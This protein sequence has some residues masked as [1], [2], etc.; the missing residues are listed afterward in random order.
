MA[1]SYFVGSIE[2]VIR[3][4]ERGYR[5]ELNII[6]HLALVNRSSESLVD[7]LVLKRIKKL[8]KSDS[9][10]NVLKDSEVMDSDPYLGKMISM[11]AR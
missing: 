6:K 9:C 8:C 4:S 7:K 10:K 3:L 1:W 5:S 11:D 2:I